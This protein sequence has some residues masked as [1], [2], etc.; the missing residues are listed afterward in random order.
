MSK[1]HAIIQAGSYKCASSNNDG[2][3]EFL[4]NGFAVASEV[5]DAQDEVPGLTATTM[6]TK[7][8][9]ATDYRLLLWQ[10]HTPAIN[11]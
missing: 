7:Q 10:S 1:W 4:N 5:D 6:G 11:I 8:R 9:L 3:N 2:S